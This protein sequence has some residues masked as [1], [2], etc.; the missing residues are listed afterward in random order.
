[1]REQK[2]L[3]KYTTKIDAF[4]TINDIQNLLAKNGA[5][6]IMTEYNQSGEIESLTFKIQIKNSARAIKLPCNPKPVYA[7]LE[8]QYRAGK[9]SRGFVNLNQAKRVAWRI[10]LAWVEAQMAIMQTQMVKMEQIFLPYMVNREGKT[11]FET[12]EENDYQLLEAKI[13]TNQVLEGTIE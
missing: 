3:Y 12:M 11:L 13:E 5:S 10:V 9:I 7:I 6:A 8:Q 1:M 2:G 4:K